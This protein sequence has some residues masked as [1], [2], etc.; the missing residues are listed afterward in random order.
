MSAQDCIEEIRRAA[1]RDLSDD[2]LDDILTTLDRERVRR[3]AEGRLESLEEDL[4]NSADEM[5]KEVVTV[6]PKRAD[7][8]TILGAAEYRAGNPKAALDALQKSS[9]LKYYRVARTQFFAA[10]AHW[11]LDE[12]DEARQSYDQAVEW[13]ERNDPEN[14]ELRRF[15]AEAEQLIERSEKHHGGSEDTEKE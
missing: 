5:A 8:W 3:A 1:G 14:E 12:K 6:A 15:R 7:S 11:Q 2:E 4:L 9:E 10:M 13:T